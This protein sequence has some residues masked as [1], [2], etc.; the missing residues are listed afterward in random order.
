MLK[1]RLEDLC[2]SQERHLRNCRRRNPDQSA[3]TW[4]SSRRVHC[5]S[6]PRTRQNHV[7]SVDCPRLAW[8]QWAFTVL[9]AKSDGGGRKSVLDTRAW[10]NRKSICVPSKTEFSSLWSSRYR[11]L[12]RKSICVPS[13]TEFFSLWSSRYHSPSDG[14]SGRFTAQFSGVSSQPLCLH[15]CTGDC[16]RQ[17]SRGTAWQRSRRS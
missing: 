16:R 17:C 3:L 8:W 9:D 10:S 12:N 4:L 14:F 7:D 6:V 15:R 2:V 13:K 11:L 1:R 5:G